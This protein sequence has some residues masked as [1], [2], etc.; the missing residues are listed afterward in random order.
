MTQHLVQLSI[1]LLLGGFMLTAPT[2]FA[3]NQHRADRLNAQKLFKGELKHELQAVDE[4]EIARELDTLPSD[5]APPS[6]PDVADTVLLFTNFSSYRAAVKCIGFDRSGT[7]I[8]R[9]LT[10]IPALGVRYLLASDIS[11][12]LHYIGHVQCAKHG[13]VEGTAIFI[14]PGLTDLPVMNRGSK[15]RIRFPFV[16]HY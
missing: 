13:R 1:L 12:G 2:A 9:S 8:G 3:G 6:D 16:A 10:R 7:P 11:N 4:V 14:G 15:S 5:I